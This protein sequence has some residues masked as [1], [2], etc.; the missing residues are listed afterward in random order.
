MEYI[1]LGLL[2]I[3][4]CVTYLLL[5]YLFPIFFNQPTSTPTVR[6]LKYILIIISLRIITHFIS[7]SIP[8][9]ALG[10]RFLHGFG[11]GFLVIV[12]CFLIVRDTKV[13]ISRFQFFL[14]AFLIA[15]ALGVANEILEFALQNTTSFIFAPTIND[16]W[17][18]LVS[19][20]VGALLGLCV[21]FPA[22]KGKK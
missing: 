21:F 5:F 20:T 15:T 13:Q 3:L 8:N 9:E 1:F 11:G 6:S 10:N 14:F 7:F 22:I 12:M 18:D 19:N 4:F 2:S 16:T 17:L